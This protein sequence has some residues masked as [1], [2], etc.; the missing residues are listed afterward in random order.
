MTLLQSSDYYDWMSGLRWFRIP[1]SHLQPHNEGAYKM[2]RRGIQRPSL[3]W[4]RCEGQQYECVSG[5]H[6]DMRH[7]Q[8]WWSDC[9]HLTHK[10]Y[11]ILF[12]NPLYTLKGQ[13]RVQVPVLSYLLRKIAGEQTISVLI[14]QLER[15]HSPSVYLYNNRF[16]GQPGRSEGRKDWYPTCLPS[17]Q[18]CSRLIHFIVWFRLS[19]CRKGGDKS[20]HRESVQRNH[21]RIWNSKQGALP[22]PTSKPAEKSANQ[23]WHHIA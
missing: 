3:R 17:Q 15:Q 2:H 13:G 4:G 14:W 7:L 22:C 8:W 21:D 5:R 10:K 18:G 6:Q 16:F 1:L 12:I 20:G 19:K 11:I 23:I 9:R